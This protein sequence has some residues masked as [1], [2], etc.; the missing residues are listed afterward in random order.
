MHTPIGEQGA[1]LRAVLIGHFRY[2][3]VPMNFCGAVGRMW[4]STLRRRS[5][6]PRWFPRSVFVIPIRSSACA[7]SPK[8]GAGC[9]SNARPDLSRSLLRPGRRPYLTRTERRLLVQLNGPASR[10]DFTPCLFSEIAA[11]SARAPGASASNL[12]R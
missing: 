9:V 4:W 3:G 12:S 6:R 7:L 1:Y 11:G 10:M 5:Q 8:A 2:Y